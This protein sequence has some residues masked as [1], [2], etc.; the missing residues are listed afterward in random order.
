ME[1]MR[2]WW[3]AEGQNFLVCVLLKVLRV[4]KERDP[5][6]LQAGGVKKLRLGWSKHSELH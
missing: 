5:S 2:R 1:V 3:C 4:E 6:P